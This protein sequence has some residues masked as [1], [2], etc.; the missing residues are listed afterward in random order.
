MS[1]R[2]FELPGRIFQRHFPDNLI[3]LLIFIFP[4]LSLSVRH[5]L[6]GIYS[7]I[8]LLATILLFTRQRSPLRREEK[9]LF[10]LFVL[11]LL[12][13]FFSATLNDWS[14]NSIRRVGNVIKYVFFFPLYLL[15]RQYT[16]AYRLLVYGTVLG[17]A[18]LGLQCLYE[19]LILDRETA[20]GMYGPIILGDLAVLF[21]TVTLVLLLF[22]KQ[23]TRSHYLLIIPLVLGILAIYLS[24]S[25]NGWLAAAISIF[26]TLALSFQFMRQKKIVIVVLIIVCLSSLASILLSE[27]IQIRFNRAATEFTSYMTHG[28]PYDEPLKHNSVGTRLESWRTALQIHKSSPWFGFGGGNAAKHVSRRAEQGLA[29]PD[30]VN[31]D[32]EKGIGGLHSTYFESLLNEGMIGLAVILAFLFYPLYLFFRARPDNP[33]LSTIG[34]IFI[35]N[36]MIFGTTENPFVHDNFTS[37]F[38][39]FLAVLFSETVN[40]KYQARAVPH[41]SGF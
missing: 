20:M 39:I 8:A 4:I 22:N 37:V 40:R 28:A 11:Y 2:L 24:G 18:V 29:H 33:A 12:S 30:F 19:I 31:P 14:D 13:F 23:Q 17:A 6:S 25:R 7:L 21:S 27:Q 32:T 10:I 5:W 41:R 36:Y 15:I 1:D 3:L 34:I 38:L 16:D 35:M 9:I 26:A